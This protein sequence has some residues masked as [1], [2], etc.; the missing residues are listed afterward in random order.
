MSRIDSLNEIKRLDLKCILLWHSNCF[1]VEMVCDAFGVP[2][3]SGKERGPFMKALLRSLCVAVVLFGSSSLSM[4]QNVFP[5]SGNVGVG[6]STPQ[7]P[8]HVMQSSGMAE[9]RIESTTDSALSYYQNGTLVGRLWYPGGNSVGARYFGFQNVLGEY[10]RFDAGD[11]R[12]IYFV[13]TGIPRVLIASDG[14]V[15]IGTTDL[16]PANLTVAGD[17][18]V[19]GNVSVAGNIAAKYQ[20]V[21]EWVKAR[22]HISPGT[23]VVLD[24]TVANQVVPSSHAYDTTVA[25]VISTKPGLVLGEAGEDKVMVATTGR[26][27]MKADA[28]RR[29]IRIGDLLVSSNVA[30]AAMASEPIDLA[31]VAVH[32]PGTIIG[33]ALEP[34]DGGQG[35]ILVLLTLQ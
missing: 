20:D 21:A 14:R 8:L 4:A 15:A 6:T 16:S 23:V 18:S 7:A 26:V 25:G 28:T 32:R 33:K 10:L 3:T 9:Q 31:G 24:R 11:N 29:P 35:E 30:G 1:F 22:E 13:T 2:S 12:P 34:L 19:T 17:T 5:A 27:K